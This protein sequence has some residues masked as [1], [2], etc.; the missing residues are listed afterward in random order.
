MKYPAFLLTPITLLTFAAVPSV[1]QDDETRQATGLPM[2]IGENVARGTRMNVSGRI[3]LESNE[4]LVRRPIITVVITHA[5]APVDKAIATDLGYY[6]VRNV[7]RDNASLIVEVDGTEVVRQPIIAPPMG[8]PRF[9][10]TVPW[11]RAGSGGVAPGV[12]VASDNYARNDRNEALFRKALEADRANDAARAVEHL[13]DVLE[14]DPKDYVAWTELG[15]IFLKNKS[16]DNAEACYFKAIELKRTYFPALLNLGGIYVN[17]KKGDDAVV[18]LSNAVKSRPTSADAHFYLGDAY[19][20]AKKG[21]SAV[22]HYN[23]ALRLAPQERADSHLRL[24]ALYDAAGAKGRASGQ[25]KL[26]LSKRP[27]H[28]DRSRLERYIAENP[29]S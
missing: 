15:S 5:G 2:I 13:N 17:R 25:Y 14:A 1:S 3:V 27:D 19:V 11:F 7:P 10:F 18:V 22:H 4:K 8:N 24:A 23:E 6:L 9:D 16:I 29:P 26:F 12:V 21:S 20:L 28:E